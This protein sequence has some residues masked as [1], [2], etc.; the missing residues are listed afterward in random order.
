MVT[1][2]KMRPVILVSLDGWGIAPPSPG[3][4]ITLAKTPNLKKFSTMYPSTRLLAAG[5]VVGLPHAEDGNSEVGHLNMGAG[6]IVYQDILRINAAITEG[7]FMR[8]EAFLLAVDHV[9]RNNSKLH[10]MGLV[11]SGS[12]HSNLE[13]LY[14][15]IWFVKEIG[16]SQSNVLLHLFTD[17][18]DAPPQEAIT[19]V[20]EIESRINR[21]GVAKIASLSGRYFAMDRDNHWDRTEKTYNCLVQGLGEKAKSV[22]E[23]IE[24]CYKQNVTDEFIPPISIIDETGNPVGLVNDNDA[25]LFFNFRP[26][27]AR[28]LA[29]VFVDQSFETYKPKH[30][31]NGHHHG[32]GREEEDTRSA[33][34]VFQRQKKLTN[35]VFISMTDY[36]KGLPVSAIAF[37]IEEVKITLSRV[38]SEHNLKQ[39]HLAETEKYAH[40]TYFFNGFREA[41][42]LNEDRIEVPS[43]K[44]ATYDLAPEMATADIVKTALSKISENIYDFI[45]INFACPDMVGHTGVIPAAVKACE[46]VDDALGKIIPAALNKGGGVVITADHGNVEEMIDITTNQV[47][48]EHSTNPVPFLAIGAGLEDLPNR[49]LQ[50]GILADVAPTV[51]DLMG[52]Q[53][54]FEMTGRDLLF[55]V[56]L[57]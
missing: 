24:N 49:T 20:A 25:V 15:L 52:M 21:L 48:T 9:K 5:E 57:K 38:I 10:L 18:R 34:G 8:N 56:K 33:Q 14:A 51:L 17:G 12:V 40:I 19:I 30:F 1:N 42:F 55:N 11:G 28:Q 4:A 22:T 54:P 7:S 53:K 50:M 47:D 44:V 45:L 31:T 36:E 2:K 29:R 41:P 16:L 26:D 23:G 27:R 37:P 35:L 43:P 46:A 13:H 6:R 3:N 32:V 39:L